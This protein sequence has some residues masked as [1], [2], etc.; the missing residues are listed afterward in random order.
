MQPKP[1]NPIK[2]ALSN[3]G[4]ILKG[5]FKRQVK[6]GPT[7]FNTITGGPATEFAHG[8]KTE[9]M[10]R[11]GLPEMVAESASIAT[12]PQTIMGAGLTR[13]GQSAFMNPGA[14]QRLKA[15]KI[16]AKGRGTV[17]RLL[18]AL[19]I[20]D[21]VKANRPSGAQVEGFNLIKKNKNPQKIADTFRGEKNKVISN[22]D[23]IIEKNN[24]PISPGAVSDRARQIL[25]KQFANSSPD[26]IS[27][28]EQAISEE[29][30]FLPVDA[31]SANARKR[32]LFQKTQGLQK[33]QRQGKTIVS[34]PEQALVEDAYAQAYREAI[35]EVLPEVAEHNKRFPGLDAGETAASKL[36]EAELE[37][38]PTGERIASQT[39]G[40]PSP[41]SSLAAFVRELPFIGSSPRRLT[42]IIEKMR[43]KHGELMTESRKL[44]APKLIGKEF[45]EPSPKPIPEPRPPYGLPFKGSAS[46]FSGPEIIDPA[47][48][49]QPLDQ[50]MYKG[51]AGNFS[52]PEIQPVPENVPYGLPGGGKVGNVRIPNVF[53]ESPIFEPELGYRGIAGN[54]TPP[55][56]TPYEPFPTSP[57]KQ[58]IMKRRKK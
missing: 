50:T 49:R 1:K 5:G 22:V 2:D 55:I 33:A 10:T 32:F 44:Q 47:D 6:A 56:E 8:V 9:A 21:D 3:T 24:K 26:E 20:A 48:L 17:S 58:S 30:R 13:L 46:S 57:Y 16:S 12:D 18:P 11:A 34:K 29:T 23:E 15:M 41:Q 39:I 31:K 42:G 19:N 37:Q 27:A 35:E 4:D 25:N 28:L 40:R 7:S 38:T 14:I 54:V 36:V 45:F 52:G 51:S 53:Q 43:G